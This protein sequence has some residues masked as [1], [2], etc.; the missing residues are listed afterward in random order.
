MLWEKRFW[1]LIADGSVT[2]T[3]RRWKRP[4]AVV[5]R[6]YRTPGGIVE[7]DRVT[8]VEPTSISARD[9][10][11]AGYPSPADVVADLR[12]DSTRSVTRVEFHLVDE[13]DPRAELAATA[14][15]SAADILDIDRR[16]ARLD[17]RSSHGPW[18]HTTLDAIV[19][20]PGTR[21]ADLAA[22]LRR[23][24]ASFKLDVRK[25]KNLGLTI[26]LETGY[27]LS[28][29]GIAYLRATGH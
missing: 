10:R 22:S 21:A 3:F 28:P 27:R 29:R 18:T 9:A 16:L 13:P 19:T 5:G 26:S 4:Q 24:T 11:R 23:D 12:G 25:L 15:L 7:V 1:P 17:S 2:V 8:T 20:R 6:R 14:Q